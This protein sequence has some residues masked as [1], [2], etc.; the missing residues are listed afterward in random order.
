MGY[1]TANDR[2]GEHA[3]SWYAETASPVPDHAPL[4]GEARAD[5]CVIGG[6]YAGLSAAL[7]LAE[8]GR[9]VV[10]LEA[11]RIGWGASG[12]NGGQLGVGPR[13]DI[14]KYERMVGRDDARKVWDIS[15]AANRLVREIIAR[16]GID[17]DLADG[18][19]EA[20]WRKSD[21]PD[22]A[23]YAGH[24]ARHYDH[25]GIELV[26]RAGVAALIGTERYHG[27]FVD[28]LGGHLHP[29]RY[30]LGLGRAAAD[31]GASIHERSRVISVEPGL[32]R[33]EA[34]SVRAENVLVACNGYLDGLTPPAA[35]R[36]LPLNNF[37]MATAPLSENRAG[38]VNRDN[39]AVCDTR[40]VLNYWR[41]TPDRRILWGGGEGA[42]RRFPVDLKS[43]VRGRMLQIY[44]DLADVEITHAWGG[45]LA[46][47]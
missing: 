8:A 10:L 18:Y 3:R 41:L 13:A 39:L 4:S 11:H 28:R 34:G 2:P 6:G 14:R 31:A 27:G 40:F 30:A 15:I 25:P 46:I 32:V 47:T 20:A 23:D 21:L 9:R 24:V 29:L 17:C 7:H 45:T 16:H 5:I 33:T 26:D 37:I 19:L 42:G 12:R 1:L 44:P 43:L 35:R 22:M 38:R 36:M